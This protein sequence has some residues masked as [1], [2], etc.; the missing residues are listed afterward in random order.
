MSFYVDHPEVLMA[1]SSRSR[2]IAQGYTPTN[3]AQAYIRAVDYAL[4]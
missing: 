4:R 2:E 1:H 3:V